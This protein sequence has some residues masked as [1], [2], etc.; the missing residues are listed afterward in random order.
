MKKARKFLA[1]LL[2]L[3]LC[4]VPLPFSVHAVHDDSAQSMITPRGPYCTCSTPDYY[5]IRV[6]NFVDELLIGSSSTCYY[7][8]YDRYQVKCRHC[9]YELWI[10]D[11]YSVA[12]PHSYE[13]VTINGREY[14][15]CTKCGYIG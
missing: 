11:I 3:T 6:G 12:M 10:E 15:Q 9:E 4:I 5:V 14:Y 13:V 8:Y 7:A 1:M 2:C